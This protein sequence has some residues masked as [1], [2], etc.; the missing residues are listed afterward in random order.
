MPML[1]NPK[2]EIF[3]NYVAQGKT[4]VESYVLAGYAESQKNPATLAN[5]PHVAE[6]IRELREKAITR[7]SVTA[8]RVLQ[9]LARLGFA[10]I[11]EAISVTRG[12]VK[13]KD[14]KD[15]DPDLRAAIAEIRSGRDGTVVK[16]HDKV[17]ALDKLGKHLGMWKD[18]LAIDVN[19]SLA[20]LVNGSFQL[21]AGKTIEGEATEQPAAQTPDKSE[22]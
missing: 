21:E 9:E 5:Q 6:R 12:K 3:A 22:A 14:T 10:D 4:Q 15:L 17:A 19:V 13:I 2:H 18:N 7:A 8:D 20:D 1:P 16:F 11:T